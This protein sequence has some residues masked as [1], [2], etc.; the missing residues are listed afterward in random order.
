[1]R[2]IG[3]VQARIGSTRLPGKVML[4][5]GGRP[6]VWHAW[7]R[8]SASRYLDQTIIVTSSQSGNER[9]TKFAEENNIPYFA[10]SES[11]LL[12][13]YHD[14]ALKFKADVILRVTA[15]CP[16]VDPD[17]IDDLILA[18]KES[19]TP[20]DY[21]SNSRPKSTYPHGLDVELFTVQAL[22][23]AHQEITDPFRREWLTTNF[24]EHPELYKIKTLM[25]PEDLSHIRLTVDY[26]SDLDLARK[27]FSELYREGQ[28]FRLK[29]ILSLLEKKPELMEACRMQDRHES[30]TSEIAKRGGRS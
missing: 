9:I 20:L 18:F 5:I 23:R 6:M 29:E 27:I 24:F 3:F 28:V 12:Q 4:D 30:Y 21:I 19:R 15:D 11:D 13:R 8:T 14:A 7:K 2:F 10:G 16:M 26:Q 1:M 25:A 22:Y 17:L